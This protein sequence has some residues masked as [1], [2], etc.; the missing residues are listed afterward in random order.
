LIDPGSRRATA[1]HGVA[2]PCQYLTPEPLH[3]IA[4]SA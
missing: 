4:R 3:R 1:V 2:V